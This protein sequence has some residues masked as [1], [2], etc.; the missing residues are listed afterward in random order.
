MRS[1]SKK[2]A[3]LALGSAFAL[4]IAVPA[5]A[6]FID[7]PWVRG[8]ENTTYQAWDVFTDPTGPNAPDIADENSN[9]TATV[10]N[11]A[12]SAFV[13]GGGNIY[14]FAEA[15]SITVSL[16]NFGLGDGYI[17]SIILQVRSL[18]TEIDP[19][20]VTLTSDGGTPIQYQSFQEIDRQ[21]LGGFGGAQV[22][23]WYRWDVAGNAS[24]Y[25]IN[26]AGLE[27]SLSLDR[28]AVDSLVTL[29]AVPEPS[30]VVLAAMGLISIGV[31]TR[32][33]RKRS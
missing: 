16:P 18:G 33:R 1:V 21:D 25:Q 27:S 6:D 4:S 23:N 3:Y 24:S 26:F 2:F 30:S 10:Q 11:S 31:A 22:D 12:A 8:S 15:L 28:V 17:T 20:S 5:R 19:A 7:P 32:F 13:T 9:G 14:S 29:S